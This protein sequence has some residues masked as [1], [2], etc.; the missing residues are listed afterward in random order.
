MRLIDTNILIDYFNGSLPEKY[1]VLIEHS[2]ISSM[3]LAEL[4]DKFQR[5]NMCFEEVKDFLKENFTILNIG[6]EIAILAA[7]IKKERR[8]KFNKFGLS[9]A[10]ILATAK[11][12]NLILYTKDKDFSGEAEVL[13]Y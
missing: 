5:E 8:K 10:L 11:T 13:N 3:T 7:K 9:D 2:F 4:A 6:F 1:L 12:N